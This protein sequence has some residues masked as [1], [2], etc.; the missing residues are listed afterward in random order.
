MAQSKLQKQTKSFTRQ[1]NEIFLNGQIRHLISTQQNKTKQKAERLT[2]KQQLKGGC[3]KGQPGDLNGGNTWWCPYCRLQTSVSHWLQRILIQLK[4]NIKS[5]VILSN[6][7]W[8]SKNGLSKAFFKT[9]NKAESQLHL[10]WFKI[11]YGGA[12]RKK[13]QKLFI[14]VKTFGLNC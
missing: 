9:S 12:Q 5:Y 10:D 13:R 7:F 4:K 1:R 14:C 6:Y 11:H 2:N 3:S 8:A